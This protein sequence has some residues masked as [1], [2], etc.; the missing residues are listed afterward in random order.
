[1]YCIYRLMSYRT[2]NTLRLGYKTNHLMIHSK[3]TAV[4]SKI[5]T[6][7]VNYIVW[8]KLSFFYVQPA[9]TYGNVK[10]RALSTLDFW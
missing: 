5:L 4:C 6:K 7:H 9:G 3:I 1:M 10:S 2:I 8:A